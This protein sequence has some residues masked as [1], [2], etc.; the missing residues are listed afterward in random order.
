MSTQRSYVAEDLEL[1]EALWKDERASATLYRALAAIDEDR[2]ELFDKLAVTEERHADHWAGLLRDAGREPAGTVTPWRHK[3]LVWWGRRFGVDRVLPAV[4]RA[5][6]ADRDRYRGLAHATVEMAD[7]EAGHGRA[8]AL[9][10][11]AG[12]GA[13]LAMADARHR[14]TAGGSLRAAVFGVNDGLVSNLALIMGVAGGATDPAVIMLAGVAGLVAGAGSMAAGEWVS[15]RSQRELFERELKVERWELEEFPDDERHELEL[16]YQ[17]KGM[18]AV[19]AAAL[20]EQIMADPDIALD[21]LAREELGLNPGDLGSPWTAAISSF[22]AFAVGAVVPLLPFL[23]G[24]AAAGAVV[25]SS[26]LSAVALATVGAVISVFT[27]RP[28]WRSGLRMVAIGGGAAAVTY[29][30][31]SLVG[32]TLG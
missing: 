14:I 1:F 29:L 28:M 4:I 19:Q 32:V 6:A 27:G 25:A 3:L 31:G 2:R 23:F 8:L 11:D 26:L 12:V 21:T 30:V 15:V 10:S 24:L 9:A 5:E 20:A 17:A 16:I 18:D 13:S 22:I 7:E